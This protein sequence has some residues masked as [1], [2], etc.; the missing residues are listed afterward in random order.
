VPSVERPSRRRRCRT[1]S[2][3]SAF[4][5]R[6]SACVYVCMCVYAR[7]R[8]RERE[9]ARERERERKRQADRQAGRQTD[10]QT[11]KS[12]NADSHSH[13][14]PQRLTPTLLCVSLLCVCV[15][16]AHSVQGYEA[17]SC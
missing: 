3:A 10:R 17:L 6:T 2:A 13:Q 15:W 9:S 7:E 4:D 11:R 16:S 14:P 8:E 5:A 1:D 12:V